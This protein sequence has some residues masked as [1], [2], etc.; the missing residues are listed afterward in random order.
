MRL[1]MV[2]RCKRDVSVSHVP[3]LANP[4]STNG[5]LYIDAP[6]EIPEA[7][8]PKTRQQSRSSLM[9]ACGTISEETQTD[10]IPDETGDLV[11]DQQS[12]SVDEPN[13]LDTRRWYTF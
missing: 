13:Q 6:D 10:S 2:V 7:K 1:D 11:V 12:V 9:T 5:K 8:K 3:Y 4:R